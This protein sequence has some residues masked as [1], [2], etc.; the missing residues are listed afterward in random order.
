ML[1]RDLVNLI[2]QRALVGQIVPDTYGTPPQDRVQQD[3]APPRTPAIAPALAY[4]IFRGQLTPP[5]GH[6]LADVPGIESAVVFW[7]RGAKG[8]GAWLIDLPADGLDRQPERTWNRATNDY[9]SLGHVLRWADS[10][11]GQ[12]ARRIVVC[13][14]DAATETLRCEV[15]TVLTPDGQP[16]DGNRDGRIDAQLAFAYSFPEAH[17]SGLP[18]VEIAPAVNFFAYLSV[19]FSDTAYRADPA[20]DTWLSV[21]VGSRTQI[22]YDWEYD[23][24]AGTP[25]GQYDLRCATQNFDHIGS[26]P[27]S[28]L[29]PF[30]WPPP[31]RRQSILAPGSSDVGCFRWEPNPTY[32]A[33]DPTSPKYA[34]YSYAYALS[35]P[36]VGTPIDGGWTAIDAA[37]RTVSQ[38]LH[39][40]QTGPRPL[41]FAARHYEH[42]GGRTI[43]GI[44]KEYAGR[45]RFRYRY[46]CTMNVS[47]HSETAVDQTAHIYIVESRPWRAYGV[48]TLR[49]GITTYEDL[50]DGVQAIARVNEGAFGS[51]GGNLSATAPAFTASWRSTG[52][53]AGNVGTL[54][55]GQRLY[56]YGDVLP[57][58]DFWIVTRESANS[59]APGSFYIAR[60]GAAFALPAHVPGGI[61]GGK[62]RAYDIR[63]RDGRV[64]VFNRG[65]GGEQL[66]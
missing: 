35:S 23:L 52:L 47:R 28:S 24:E 45:S 15:F 33:S 21:N 65:G 55:Q 48:L 4:L 26:Y 9:F 40:P 43:W 31:M 5:V 63:E 61:F 27:Q 59:E 34:V 7:L 19:V 10:R 36:P 13:S 62:P 30:T 20:V 11:P 66:R 57:D 56:L 6:P 25:T 53:S 2:K 49:D 3:F 42:L 8:I 18:T 37:N 1:I 41:S 14:R 32:D 50:P 38:F 51:S 29:P 44:Q 60:G 58:G 46:P 64:W 16:R 22:G 17:A 54:P 12:V 39:D